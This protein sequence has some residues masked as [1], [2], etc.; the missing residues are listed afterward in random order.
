MRR[1]RDG[2]KRHLLSAKGKD[3]LSLWAYLI[4]FT[5]SCTCEFVK[6]TSAARRNASGDN[7]HCSRR[8]N[9]PEVN[10]PLPYRI[11]RYGEPNH[12]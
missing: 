9:I 11:S 12:Q 4:C 3:D 10:V 2:L 8:E 6:R 7:R 5:L 1:V